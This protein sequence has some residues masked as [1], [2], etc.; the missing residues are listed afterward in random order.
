MKTSVVT[1]HLNRLNGVVLVIDYNLCFK[2]VI[3][4]IIPK[5]SLLP[6]LSGAL[7][8]PGYTKIDLRKFFFPKECCF[9]IPKKR[10]QARYQIY[11]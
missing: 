4:K 6:F 10:Y 2:E 1:P 9:R 8:K 5:L 11:Y 7:F 3:W